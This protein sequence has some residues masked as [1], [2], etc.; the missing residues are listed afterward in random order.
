MT[1]LQDDYDDDFYE[2]DFTDDDED[3]RGSSKLLETSKSIV[4]PKLPPK[5]TKA[6]TNQTSVNTHRSDKRMPRRVEGRVQSSK[7]RQHMSLRNQYSEL[8]V[9]YDEILKENKLLKQIQKRQERE[10]DK[11]NNP[12]EDLPRLLDANNYEIAGLKAKNKQLLFE[13]REQDDKLRRQHQEII[14]LKEQNKK[15]T[16]LANN[17]KLG[18][19]EKLELEL[20]TARVT[21]AHQENKIQDLT[22]AV[23]IYKKAAD[24]EVK[25]NQLQLKKAQNNL[26]DLQ[27]AYNELFLKYKAKEKELGN[28]NIYAQRGRISSKRSN[29]RPGQ[30]T[31]SNP[32]MN[33]SVNSYV[34]TATPVALPFEKKEEKSVKSTSALSSLERLES[35]LEL[36]NQRTESLV[37]LE[38]VLEEEKSPELPA[39]SP[40]PVESRPRSPSTLASDSEDDLDEEI[41]S[42]TPP[43]KPSK[44]ATPK[45]PS[46]AD[47][48]F[49]PP[50]P[51]PESELQNRIQEEARLAQEEEKRNQAEAARLAEEATR[52]AEEAAR[53]AEEEA[54]KAREAS[55]KA[56]EEKKRAEEAKAE[57][58]RAAAKKIEDEEAASKAEE[59]RL[60]LERKAKDDALKEKLAAVRANAGGDF[61]SQL[62]AK[63]ATPVVS[64][65]Q[66]VK[67]NA[68][69]PPA[70]APIERT[71]R[72]SGS[73]GELR[74]T[75]ALNNVNTNRRKKSS[76]DDL[77]GGYQPSFATS[78]PVIGKADPFGV[79]INNGSEYT[80]SFSN[81]QRI[82]RESSNNKGWTP[83]GR[84]STSE[85]NGLFEASLDHKPILNRR[86]SKSKNVIPVKTYDQ[87]DDL[88]ELML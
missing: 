22:K 32:N 77:T 84:A 46:P 71:A 8:S 47:T 65:A 67:S 85:R 21:I 3:G 82:S 53:K 20:T 78:K 88:E 11:Y 54:R 49:T 58:A 60:L 30:S 36:L 16:T 45:A 69:S 50:D 70:P 81:N 5:R 33:L 44:V 13:K 26:R 43:P 83:T 79:E 14:S 61:M 57:K 6:F 76:D 17:R 41:R 27:D 10:L 80:P 74:K 39:K 66:S 48:E 34:S 37:D 19:R 18:E 9:N 52:R 23:E 64:P 31:Q 1:D 35:E 29:Y 63:K 56:E 25:G 2:D 55:R 40:S 72:K 12:D 68:A 24:R 28:Q 51:S 38:K 42:P 15:M 4:V 86:A 87:D 7:R 59:Q 62:K 75:A 73:G